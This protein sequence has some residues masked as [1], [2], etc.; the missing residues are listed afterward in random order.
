MTHKKLLMI[1]DSST[2]LALVESWLSDQP[3]ILYTSKNGKEGL[4]ESIKLQPDLILLDILMPVQ[5]GYDTIRELRK[6]F[7]TKHIPVIFISTKNSMVDQQWGLRQGAQAY[8][9]K[10]FNKQELLQTIK[11]VLENP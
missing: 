11:K 6:D 3:F 7:K 5:N 1:D 10:P 8:L 9:S 2:D 4:E